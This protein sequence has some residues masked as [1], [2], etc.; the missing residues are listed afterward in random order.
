M[1]NK[2]AAGGA[3]ELV[4]VGIALVLD[5]RQLADAPIGLTQLYADLVGQPHQPLARPIEEL[6]IGREH[7]RLGLLRGVD[8]NPGEVGRLH[9][10]GSGRHRQALLQ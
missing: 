7:H 2:L 1:R 6:G 8:H 5:E 9:R 10:R 4:R 3:L